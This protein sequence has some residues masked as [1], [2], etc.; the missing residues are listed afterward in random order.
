[1][2]GTYSAPELQPQPPPTN[3]ASLKALTGSSPALMFGTGYENPERNSEP[4]G[5]RVRDMPTHLG[6]EKNRL[7]NTHQVINLRAPVLSSSELLR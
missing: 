7:K 4:E 1:M 5:S 6:G 3:L 2:Q